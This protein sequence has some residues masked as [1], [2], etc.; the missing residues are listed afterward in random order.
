M[1]MSRKATIPRTRAA[2]TFVEMSLVITIVALFATMVVPNLAHW[3]AG[4]PYREFPGKLMQLVAKTR[5]DA[6]QNRDARAIGFD[7]STGEFRV[8]WTDPQTSQEQEGQRLALPEGLEINRLVADDTDT[9]PA[10]WRV[11]FYADGT[12]DKAG[13]ELRNQDESLSVAVS[14]LGSAQL[15]KTSLPESAEERWPAGENETRQ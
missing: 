7:E 2:F 12:A 11:T 10:A 15:L 3:R 8:F 1:R 14:E 4:I 9:A 13:I 6:I 5:Q